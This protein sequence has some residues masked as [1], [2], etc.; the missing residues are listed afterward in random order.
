MAKI[1]VDFVGLNTLIYDPVVFDT[2]SNILTT[3]SIG[4]NVDNSIQD[5]R[6]AK[7]TSKTSLLEPNVLAALNLHRN[8]PYGFPTFK[9][10]RNA[11]KPIVKYYKRNSIFPYI[12]T[13][14]VYT[15]AQEP[16]VVFKNYP[17]EYDVSLTDGST[18]KIKIS[19]SNNSS[20]FANEKTN[21][22]HDIDISTII[23][24]EN[25][26]Y[27]QFNDLYLD[28]NASTIIDS[29]NSIK[30]TTTIFPRDKNNISDLRDR[31]T[32]GNLFW[33]GNK[34]DRIIS[35]SSDISPGITSSMWAT[36]AEPNFT[37]FNITASNPSF[38]R[39]MCSANHAPSGSGVLQN[40]ST[41]IHGGQKGAGFIWQPLQSLYSLKH[42][43]TQ[44]CSV[45]GPSGID[46]Y[47]TGT[48]ENDMI[49]ARHLF[50]G[51]AE[52]QAAHQAGFNVFSSTPQDFL[53][54][55]A[56]GNVFVSSS[57][58]PFYNSYDDYADFIRFK[59]KGYSVLPEYRITEEYDK[60]S[61]GISI[62]ALNQLVSLNAFVLTGG[63]P[64]VSSSGLSSFYEIY[65]FS[66][67]LG[68]D[69][70]KFIDDHDGFALP[71]TIKLSA[72]GIVK[73]LPYKGFYPADR[74][75]QLAEE[76]YNSHIEKVKFQGALAL[77]A[78]RKFRSFNIPF[79]AP[80][81]MY[82]TIK[83]G[84]ACDFPI[85]TSS[86]HITGVVGGYGTAQRTDVVDWM[87]QSA[88]GGDAFF[89]HRIPFEAIISPGSYVKNL[90]I[91]NMLQHPS[92]SLNITASLRQSGDKK[93]KLMAENFFA[94]VP[95]F[96]LPGGEFTAMY[97]ISDDESEF[98]NRSVSQACYGMRVKLYRSVKGVAGDDTYPVLRKGYDLPQDPTGAIG[99]DGQRH[100]VVQETF[101]MYSRPSAFGPATIGM[102]RQPLFDSRGGYNFP[103]TPPYYHGES[104]ADII[105]SPDGGSPSK[106]D[107]DDIFA[108]SIVR[109]HRVVAKKNA[110]D[111]TIG[112]AIWP[113][114]GDNYGMQG[115]PRI[116]DNSMQVSASINLFGS[117]DTQAVAARFDGTTAATTG[118]RWHIGPKFETPMFNFKDVS[119][120]V[121]T[122]ASQSVP[123]GMWHQF[124]VTPTDDNTGIF[125]E[126]ADIPDDWIDGRLGGNSGIT[127]SLADLVGISK[128]SKR[129]GDCAETRE[130]KEAI[131]LVPFLEESSGAGGRTL[132]SVD[133]LRIE[134]AMGNP[135]A[136]FPAG[137]SIQ[138][139]VDKMQEYYLPPELDFV[140]DT[141]LD[142]FAMFFL[143][144]KYTLTKQDLSYIWQNLPPDIARKFEEQEVEYEFDISTKELFGDQ[145]TES[146]GPRYSNSTATIDFFKKLRF[147]VFKVKK[148]AA[149]SYN[150]KIYISTVGGVPVSN[151]KINW[152]YDFFS[153]V[154]YSKIN[155]SVELKEKDST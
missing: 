148:R 99:D 7:F 75:T 57:R 55:G 83:S 106:V 113:Q 79:Y 150:D 119:S 63:L 86:F 114:V 74:A 132:I 151:A 22:D 19:Y 124:G 39:R 102:S 111:N 40:Y 137:D 131:V 149:F 54:Y 9:Q 98:G 31:P 145:I 18:P 92:A 84:I 47:E 32:F 62:T 117:L 66:D 42:T 109:Y 20:Y 34:Q 95:N 133:R 38:S 56:V 8:G 12:T 94:E 71:K 104:W 80:G 59:A 16:A 27:N 67:L 77:T 6:N 118:R 4:Y 97:S 135:S 138:D 29:V 33:K 82:N 127:G 44:T 101:T 115:S 142:P 139:M 64:E 26:T 73:L 128:E 5:Y 24:N 136:L 105:Y 2:G 58:N 35:G 123:R 23:S 125:M 108:K 14:R 65:S 146:W 43:S 91:V 81:I 30:Y 154:E 15:V 48:L 152:P 96:F 41:H 10:I 78:P 143:E 1:K 13:N 93:Y 122:F 72:K 70:Q 46:I 76:F 126:I 120:S 36:D 110:A 53:E 88:S 49:V 121:P 3:A 17:L 50:G 69:F 45:V 37:T 60:L 89:G 51:N 129:L 140:S 28:E 144:F 90:K 52:W 103:Y 107:L 130:I 141:S 116:N 153:L 85:F 134:T 61:S 25:S 155:M 112:S 100:P 68:E 147:M 11:N 87:I 21:S